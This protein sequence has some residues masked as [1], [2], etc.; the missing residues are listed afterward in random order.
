MEAQPL[1]PIKAMPTT[2][3][4]STDSSS[5]DAQSIPRT[6]VRS[7]SQGT[8]QGTFHST[9]LLCSILVTLVLTSYIVTFIAHNHS[10]RLILASNRRPGFVSAGIILNIYGQPRIVSPTFPQTI[11]IANYTRDA[12]GSGWN[13]F[14]VHVNPSATNSA[15]DYISAMR[16][17]GYLEGALTCAEIKDFYLNYYS[18]TFEGI[19]PSKE[20][21]AFLTDNYAWMLAQSDRQYRNSEYWLTVKGVLSQLQGLLDGMIQGCPNNGKHIIDSD[22]LL[23]MDSP[24]LLH[25]LLLNAN[26]DLFT[27]NARYASPFTVQKDKR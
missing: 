12:G 20:T 1:L 18:S 10:N 27:I 2:T 22:Y 14:D 15:D 26:G 9:I 19:S 24:T 25:L 23:N 3:S 7:V 8:F 6:F 21:I 17:V 4:S 13:Y 11:A 16:V 5:T